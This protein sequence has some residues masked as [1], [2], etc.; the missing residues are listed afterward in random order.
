MEVQHRQNSLVEMDFNQDNFL[1][2]VT[3]SCTGECDGM[4][5]STMVNNETEYIGKLHNNY[6]ENHI[7]FYLHTD[8]PKTMYHQKNQILQ[9]KQN[10]Q[11]P[12]KFLSF[13]SVHN[14]ENRY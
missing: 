14:F 5:F 7:Q 9:E 12:S 3:C 4:G 10:R 13:N 8:V 6:A 1:V 11:F 2:F